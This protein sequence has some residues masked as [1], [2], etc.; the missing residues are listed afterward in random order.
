MR[1]SSLAEYFEAARGLNRCIFR[2]RLLFAT[3]N[4]IE[5]LDPALSRPGRMDVW[6]NFKNA[7]KWQAEG[8][9][10]CF[11][12]SAPAPSAAPTPTP[13][14]TEADAA[15]PGTDKRTPPAAQ[16]RRKQHIHGVPLLTAEELETLAKKFAE[17]IPEG[18]MSVASLQGYLLKNK[19]RLPPSLQGAVRRWLNSVIADTASGV[20]GGGSRMG[21]DRTRDAGE[22]QEG[23][24]RG[25][26]MRAAVS[27]L[28]TFWLL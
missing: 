12:P 13:A 5:R 8:I 7:T 11:F 25:R 9:F 4:H 20:R 26:F 19:V 3:T 23:E 1:F 2:N 24:G 27:S 6:I 16:S 28:L 22:A 18:E 17:A 21:Q 15:K 10:K 14:A